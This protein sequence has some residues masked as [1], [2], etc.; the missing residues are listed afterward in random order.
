MPSSTK[1]PRE[2][3]DSALKI[4][5]MAIDIAHHSTHVAQVDDCMLRVLVSAIEDGVED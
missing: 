3:V 5:K 2:D 1:V 4:A